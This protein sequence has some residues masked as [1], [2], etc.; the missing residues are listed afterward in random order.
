M[1]PSRSEGTNHGLERPYYGDINIAE[2]VDGDMLLGGPTLVETDMVATFALAAERMSQFVVGRPAE[3]RIKADR[4]QLRR[5][6]Q[7]C[8]GREYEV[9]CRTKGRR[10]G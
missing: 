7:E 5:K 9:V 3:L 2:R 1:S 10:R 4:A 8:H 6:P